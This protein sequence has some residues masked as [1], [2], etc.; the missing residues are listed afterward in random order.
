MLL[1][2]GPSAISLFRADLNF[3]EGTA[4]HNGCRDYLFNPMRVEQAEHVIDAGYGF[5]VEAHE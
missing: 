5:A 3:G 1:T 4:A 2:P